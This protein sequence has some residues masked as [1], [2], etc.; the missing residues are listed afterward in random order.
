VLDSLTYPFYVI[1][2]T[3]Y[4]VCL[5]NRAARE[6]SEHH[7]I[8]CYA[9]THRRD[10]PCDSAGHPCPVQIV[11]KTKKPT[12]VE[13]IH[14]YLGEMR[15]VEVHAFPV[16]DDSG[17]VIQIIEYC[18]DITDR[19]RADEAV[20]EA[21]EQL[22]VQAEQLQKTN[23]QLVV[24]GEELRAANERLSELTGTLES[25]VVQRTTQLQHR[26][27]QLQRLA[28]ELS[29]AEDR[30]RRRLAEV[31]HDDMQQVLAAAK[32]HLGL[33]KDRTPKD[34]SHDA[35][36]AQTDRMLKDAI[37]K[38][39]NL[40]HELSPAALYQCNLAG[41]FE[42]LAGQVQTKHGLTVDVR[43]DGQVRSDLEGLQM[44][45]YRAAQ[46]MLFN[47]VKHAGINQ[48][49]LRLRR[50]GRWVCLTVSDRG[51]GFDPR[52]LTSST[53]FGL[54]SIRER[55]ELLGGRMKIKSAKG[56]GSTFFIAV[57]DGPLS[58]ADVDRGSSPAS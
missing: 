9:L 18:V 40:S 46:E 37:E 30:E 54:L 41:T 8:T 58:Q 38:S 12:V 32:F 20:Q 25:K 4:Q 13:H 23:E 53:G 43:A 45:L 48:A 17:Q 49:T 36:L 6:A 34:Q 35:I 26:A 24:R 33:L 27:K 1:D 19:K 39:R 14:Y 44:F 47:V 3:N 56:K 16:L 55:I 50:M 31:L 57:P 28:Q 2:A 51:Q 7:A 21:H 11:K 52:E 29:Q 22:R 5:A 15:N 10:S 42:W